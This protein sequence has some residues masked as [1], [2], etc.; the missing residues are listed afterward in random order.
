MVANLYERLLRSAQ[1]QPALRAFANRYGRA[2]WRLP[3]ALR[4]RICWERN[5]PKLAGVEKFTVGEPESGE[6][7]RGHAETLREPLTFGHRVVAQGYQVAAPFVARFP[8]VWLVGEYASPVT[9]DGRLLLNA[10]REAPRIFGLERHAG[11]EAWIGAQGYRKASDQP[12]LEHVWSMV[13]RLQANYFHWIVEWCGRLEWLEIYRQRTG[14]APRLLIPLNGPGYIRASLEGLGYG[15]E[16]LL[17]WS[18]DSPPRLATDFLLPSFRGTNSAPSSAALL[19][20]RNRFLRSVG[21]TEG[22]A[23]RRVYVPR[24]PGVWRAVRNSSEVENYLVGQGFEIVEPHLLSFAEQIRLFSEVRLLVGLH[25][26]AMTNVLFAPGASMLELFGQY[27]D[28]AYFGMTARLGQPY[29]AVRCQEVE[30]QDVV[31]DLQRL[32]RRIESISPR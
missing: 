26:A 16:N 25:G 5:V 20:L 27:G 15:A 7:I 8:K 14:L 12:P 29:E 2:Y 6:P 23:F 17:E 21:V 18:P 19:W 24:R 4:R 9:G 1:L 10:F 28:G 13:N 11:M 31:V 22:K 32:G 30:N 3:K